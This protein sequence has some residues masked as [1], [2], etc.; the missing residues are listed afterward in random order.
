MTGP[1]QLTLRVIGLCALLVAGIVATALSHTLWVL[2]I[3]LA[4]LLA[5]AAAMALSVNAMLGN[6]DRA[7]GSE[8][9]RGPTAL[10]AAISAL[11]IVLAIALPVATSAAVSTTTPDARSAADTVRAFLASAVIDN[12]SYA[13]CEYLAPSAQAQ[14]ATMAGYGQTCRDALAAT[15]PSFRGVTSE[16]S[17]HALTLRAAV[18]DGTAFV[19]GRGVTFALRPATAAEKSAFQAPQA[20]WRI[21]SGATAVLTA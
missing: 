6:D 16:G 1:G 7:D 4:G 3:T 13:A 8:P 19:T 17:L 15:T 10:L 18:R 11:T 14:V 12:N 9:Y 2:L 21:V 5:A 20:D